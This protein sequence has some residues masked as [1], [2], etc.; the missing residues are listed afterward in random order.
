LKKIVTLLIFS[1]LTPMTMPLSHTAAATP[2][3]D[4]E[5]S[6]TDL[7]ATVEYLTSL[8]PPRN[9][10]NPA[11]MAR[12]ADYIAK[13]F[14]EYGLHPVLQEFIVSG[15]TYANIIAAAGPEVGERIIVGAHYDVCADTPGADDNGSGVAALLELARFARKRSEHLSYRFEFV[16]YALEE[17]PHFGTG[18]M[19]SYVHAASLHESKAMVRGMICLEMLGY[20][21][22]EK[23]SQEYPLGLMKLFYPRTGDFIAVV[24]NFASNSLISKVAK[25]LN[26]S[27]LVVRTLRAPSFVTGVDFSDHRNYWSFGYPAVMVTDTSFY[28][29]PHYHQ[30]TDQIETLSFEKLQQ[31]V[32]GLCLVLIKM[33]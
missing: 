4:Q 21:T 15:V 30:A 3:P 6:T 22:A 26:E 25:H 16:A 27:D 32:R 2:L 10:A 28:R 9:S 17:P 14:T 11:S 18:N 12:A 5:I 19:G 31:V 33:R 20:F 1:F 29:N 24:G 13:K 7:R 8:S 23:N